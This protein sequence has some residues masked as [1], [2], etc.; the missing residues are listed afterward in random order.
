MERERE[1]ERESTLFDRIKLDTPVFCTL[2]D[3]LLDITPN[4]LSMIW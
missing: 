3:P 4:D 1:R 2:Q